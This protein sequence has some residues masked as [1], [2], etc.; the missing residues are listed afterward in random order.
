MV[1]M[2]SNKANEFFIRKS[3]PHDCVSHTHITKERL[4]KDAILI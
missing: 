3:K 4:D 2:I 1:I